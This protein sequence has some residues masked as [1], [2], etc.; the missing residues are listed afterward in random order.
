MTS[1][2]QSRDKA[3]LLIADADALDEIASLGFNNSLDV[4][5]SY[6]EVVSLLGEAGQAADDARMVRIRNVCNLKRI[7]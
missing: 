7:I 6:K 1:L 3:D 2:F 5:N 4:A